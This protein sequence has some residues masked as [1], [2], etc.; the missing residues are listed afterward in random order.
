[1]SGILYDDSPKYKETYPIVECFLIDEIHGHD[2]IANS[3][4]DK[5]YKENNIEINVYLPEE[6]NMYPWIEVTS[7]KMDY[8][9]VIEN[10]EIYLA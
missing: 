4:E 10:G 8:S 9:I 7:S 6:D 1:M 5:F 2:L 3:E